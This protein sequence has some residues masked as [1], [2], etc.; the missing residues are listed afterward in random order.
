MTDFIVLIPARMGS[1]RLPKKMLSRIADIPLIVRTAK[2][3]SKSYAK[4]VIVATDHEDIRQVCQD[5]G[6]QVLMTSDKHTSGTERL[7]EA[8]EKLGILDDE[9]IIINVQGDE[10]FIQPQ[11]IN[12]L[13]KFMIE[14]SAHVATVAHP[15][16]EYQDILNPNIVKVVLDSQN[17]AMYFS[18]S[19]I[20]FDRNGTET[21]SNY[22]KH[23]GIYGYT[24]SFLR[25]FRNMRSCSLEQMES[26]EQLR[27]LYHGVKI[28]VLI[29]SEY[30]AAGIDVFDDLTRARRVLDTN[31]DSRTD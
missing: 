15:F 5:Y 25:N 3:A 19:L 21:V 8:V 11:L 29:S 26:L 1:T 16:S 31:D 17:F 24:V 9:Q 10:V 28:A 13:A 27:I 4:A 2:Q 22:L 6:V 12:D 23:V 7:C 18:R 14:N 20:P 30:H